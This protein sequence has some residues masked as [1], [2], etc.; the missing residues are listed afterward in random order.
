[1]GLCFVC[2]KRLVDA[3]GRE[4]EG[5]KRSYHGYEV[6][7]HKCCATDFAPEPT[8]IDNTQYRELGLRSGECD[9]SL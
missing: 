5:V 4:V 7:M 2:G 3:V 6:R 9:D 8:A 1:M